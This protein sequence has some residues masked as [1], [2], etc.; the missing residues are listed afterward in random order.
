MLIKDLLQGSTHVNEDAISDLASELKKTEA[1]SYDAIDAI[2]QKIAKDHNITAKELHNIWVKKYDEKPDDWIKDKLN[3]GLSAKDSED[4]WI[5]TFVNSK[6]PKFANKSREERVRM[7]K[8][9]RYRTVQN[10]KFNEVTTQRIQLDFDKLYG[11]AFKV[12]DNA[13]NPSL[14]GF[15]IVTPSNSNAWT[16][17]K[18]RPEFKK[19]VKQKLNDPSFLGDHKY[20]QIIDAMRNLGEAKVTLYTDPKYFGADVKDNAGEGLSVQEIPLN[21]LVG[22]EPDDK[23]QD[24]KSAAN[25]SKMVELLKAGKGKDLP[26]ILVRKY[27]DGYQVLDGHHRF[28][29]YKKAGM[30]TIPGK[31]VP[32]EDIETI[33]KKDSIKEEKNSISFNVTRGKQSFS[34]SMLIGIQ[35]VGV[36]EYDVNSGRT[37]VELDNNFKGQGLGKLLILKGIYTA[38]QLGMDY[39]EDESRTS[40]FDN[41]IDS[42]ESN[43]LIVQDDGY[44]YVTQDGEQYL[45]DHLTENFADG[46]NPGRKGLAKRS[47]VNT[48]ASVSSLR[49]TAKNS[50]GEKQRMAHWLAN[51]KSGKKK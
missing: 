49:K 3:E 33:D 16:E 8:A 27:K 14:P 5:R 47:G 12:V 29:A 17:W 38:S 34:L 31:V 22:F 13:G 9:A 25:M 30:K 6:H 15:S 37:L 36:F 41:V 35:D 50:T 20:Q 7:A 40:S 18:E 11:K 45:K 24:P 21:K 28:H 42:L 1:T 32:D 19:V 43:G 10:K 44:F 48:K 46:K 26:P 51:M 39:I 23:M 4:T 2:M